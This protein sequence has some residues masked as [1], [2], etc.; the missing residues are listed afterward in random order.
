MPSGFQNALRTFRLAVRSVPAYKNLLA[1]NKIR[2]E[3]IKTFEDFQSLP[4]IDK[5]SYINK[6]PIKSLYVNGRVLPMVGASSGSSGK[7]TFWFCGEA[8][9]EYGGQIHELIFR[10]IFK[11][12]K[13]EPTL[14]I[15][16]FSMG[17]WVAGNYTLATCRWVARQGY[18][19]TTVTPGIDKEDILSVLKDLAP[20]FKNIVLAGYPPF[21]M[22]TV[23]EA[24]KR[25]IPL[26][27]NIK[28]LTAG[29]KFSEKF[30]D[31]LASLL[32]IS[33]LS[34]FLIGI[35]GSADAGVLGYETP[36]TI[37]LRKYALSNPDL[38]QKLFQGEPV[39]PALKQY[40]PNHIYFEQQRGEL[41]FT[42]KTGT[43]LVRYNIHDTGAVITPKNLEEIIEDFALSRQISKLNRA[44]LNYP[45]LVIKGRSD[46]A[47]T[48]YALN[49]LPEH[50][51]AGVEDKS[52]RKYVTGRLLSYNETG[53]SET[54]QNLIIKLELIKGVKPTKKIASLA[55]KS[56][57]DNLLKLNIEYR[58]LHSELGKRTLPLIRFVEF[59]SKKLTSPHFQSILTT[60]GKKPKVIAAAK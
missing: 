35:Y 2:A 31:K 59:G 43:P 28:I 48:F 29:D 15:I 17:V 38:Y 9:E 36:L 10:D 1:R 3:K 6:Y 51:K 54:R 20:E 42:A 44:W 45:L 27:K 49:I 50:L 57:F 30:R 32:G 26:K 8:Q 46:V 13:D 37:Y 47:V 16:C 4:I 56:I 25:G 23:L 39:E 55:G 53:R 21:I 7:P 18:N 22:D 12:R 19:L 40:N 58:K 14:V 34:N 24:K 41:L 60:P 52:I 11:F 33:P 5:K